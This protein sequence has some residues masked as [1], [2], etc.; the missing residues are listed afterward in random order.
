LFPFSVAFGHLFAPKRAKTHFSGGAGYVFNTP[1]LTL[2]N[3]SLQETC[4]EWYVPAMEDVQMSR[5]LQQLNVPLNDSHEF[6]LHRF[7][8]LSFTSLY[9]SEF[10]QW[11]ADYN[12]L[13]IYDGYDCCSSNAISFHYTPPETMNLIDWARYTNI[14]ND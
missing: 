4:G 14:Q 8:P 6:N 5:C 9:K 12:T 1:V 7:Y 10:P 2:M 11:Y 3:P 13:P